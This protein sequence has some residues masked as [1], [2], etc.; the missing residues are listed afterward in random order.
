MRTF[1]LLTALLIGLVT[2]AWAAD[3][4]ATGRVDDVRCQ[5]PITASP[6]TKRPQLPTRTSL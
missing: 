3:D 4:V 6:L 5:P 1:V 2:P